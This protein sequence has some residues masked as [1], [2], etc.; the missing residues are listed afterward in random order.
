MRVGIVAGACLWALIIFASGCAGM[1]VGGRAG[2]YRV[3]ETQ[4]SYATHARNT[5]PLKCLF[6]NCDQEVERGS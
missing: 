5:K 4:S 3:D 2:I 1:E 6:V